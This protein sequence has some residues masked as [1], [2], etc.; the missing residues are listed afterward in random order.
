MSGSSTCPRSSSGP[1]TA[2]WPRISSGRWPTRSQRRSAPPSAW[3]TSW[4][5]WRRPRTR[6]RGA[7]WRRCAWTTSASGRR[8]PW[9]SRCRAPAP[10]PGAGARPRGSSRSLSQLPNTARCGWRSRRSWRRRR[11]L[12]RG[13]RWLGAAP[14]G[15][16]RARAA[17]GTKAVGAGPR[18]PRA[19]RRS[20]RPRASGRPRAWAGDGDRATRARAEA[21][22]LFHGMISVTGVPL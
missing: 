1:C 12:S 5:S 14:A 10:R 17:K 15:R 7:P 3:G 18:R 21:W 9:P 11:T 19:R 22:V 6:R 16:M 20:R 4:P 8:P 13:R 2:P